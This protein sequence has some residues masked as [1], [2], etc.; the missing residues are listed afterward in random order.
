MKELPIEP[1]SILE[2]TLTLYK[3]HNYPYSQGGAYGD[4]ACRFHLLTEDWDEKTV[5]WNTQPA[6]DSNV[7]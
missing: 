3:D 2:I 6:F 1:D 4:N 7:Y 5:T